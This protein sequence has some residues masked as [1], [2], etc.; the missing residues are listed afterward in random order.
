[1]TITHTHMHTLDKGLYIHSNNVYNITGYS[2]FKRNF[3]VSEL[4]IYYCFKISNI[5]LKNEREKRKKKSFWHSPKN[6][7]FTCKS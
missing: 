2:V 6:F 4:R 3:L 1:M 5:S 7:W